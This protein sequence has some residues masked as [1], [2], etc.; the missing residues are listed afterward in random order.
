[1]NLEKK[2]KQSYQG[3]LYVRFMVFGNE[4]LQT[5]YDRSAGFF[6]RQIILTTKERDPNRIDDPYLAE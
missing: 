4:A 1:M 6:R 2:G 5:L 3:T